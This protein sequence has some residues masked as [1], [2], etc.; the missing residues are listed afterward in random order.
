MC[1]TFLLSGNIVRATEPYCSN[2]SFE[3]GDFTNWAGYTWYN[4]TIPEVR[5]TSPAYGFGLQTIMTDTNAYDA[6]TNNKIKKVPGGY[7]YSARLGDENSNTQAASLRYTLT[8]DSL[9]AFLTYQFAVVLLNPTSGHTRAEEPRFKVTI[10][11]N[12][13]DTIPDCSNYDVYASDAELNSSF[14]SYT[15]PD[16]S[17]PVLYRDWTSVGANLLPYLG[18]T[19]TI[20]FMATDCTHRG[21]YGYAY[22]VAN[23]QPLIITVQYCAGD[24][25]ARLSGPIG[26]ET[27]KWT[28]Q[29]GTVVGKK[30]VLELSSPTEGAYYSCQM[31]SATGCTLS[32]H[33]TIARYEP[34]ADFGYDLVDCNKLA[35]K[36]RFSNPHPAIHGTLNYNWDF[37]DGT[38]STEKNPEHIFQSSGMHKVSLVVSNPPSTCSDS[39]TREVETF[40]PPL[41]GIGGDSTYCATQPAI[42]KGYGAHHYKWSDGSTADSLVVTKNAQV[43]LIGY[44]SMGCYTDTIRRSITAEPDWDLTTSGTPLFCTGGSTTLSASGAERYLWSTNDTTSSILVDSVGTYTLLAYNKRGCEKQVSFNVVEDFLPKVTDIHLSSPTVDSRHNVLACS[45]PAESGV[46]YSWDMGDNSTET[47]ASIS[48]TYEVSSVL[49]DYKIQLTATNENGCTNSITQTIDIVPFIPNVFT[50]N[51][52]NVNDRFLTGYDVQIFDR[53]GTVIYKGTDGWNGMY[54]GK[55]ADN[56]TYFYFIRYV[57][58]NQQTQTKK[59]AV[60]LKR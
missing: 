41:V 45:I 34:N 29:D 19:I 59:G 20:E 17:Q 33:S 23:C 38:K 8:V 15:P 10:L 56:D 21:H 40:Y 32:L 57:D 39:L 14:V 11:D 28:T 53:T 30:Q 42:L 5:S 26:F 47:G 54:K 2:I 31:T 27:Y 51:N 16:S 60:T 22:L 13:G 50:P 1:Y 49:N 46:Q 44:S 24:N 3:T 6:K 43:W 9:N 35:N 48:H 36:I 55:P 7:R 52:D 18:K 37:G 4:S 25:I 58:K 12:N